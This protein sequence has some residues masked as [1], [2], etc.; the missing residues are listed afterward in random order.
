MKQNSWYWMAL[1]MTDVRRDTSLYALRRI[2]NLH[3]VIIRSRGD[4]PTNRGPGY[5]LYTPYY[6]SCRRILIGEKFLA[7]RRVPNLHLVDNIIANRDNALAIRGPGY[8]VRGV[9]MASIGQDGFASSRIP[10]L[11]CMI[12]GSRGDAPA[13]R[14]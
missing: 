3:R 2:P 8:S 5:G 7:I 14:G 4:A 13:I 11:H 12:I 1:I 9:Y 10:D 6:A